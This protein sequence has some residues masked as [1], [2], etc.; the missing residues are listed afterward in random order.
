MTKGGGI[1]PAALFRSRVASAVARRPSPVARA[2]RPS[3]AAAAGKCHHSRARVSTGVRTATRH[4]RGV[5]QTGVAALRMMRACCTSRHHHDPDR[6]AVCRPLL[7]SAPFCWRSAAPSWRRHGAR[8]RSEIPAA[9]SAGRQPPIVHFA[10]ASARM[11]G[12]SGLSA[13]SIHTARSRRRPRSDAWQQRAALLRRQIQVALGL[14][15]LPIRTPLNAR[16]HGTVERDDYVVD[17]VAF[18]SVPGHFVTGSLYRPKNR[19]GTSTRGAVAARSLARRTL[20]GRRRRR[21]R[22]GSDRERGGA[23]SSRRPP[24][25]AGARR[26]PRAHGR[27]HVPVRHGGIRRQ[28]ADPARGHR[29]S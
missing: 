9:G 24:S 7:R 6:S 1:L 2:R 16:V 12:V 17:K 8:R 10:R 15:P 20:S 21:S 13:I 3:P 5:R 11:T 26:A 22:A 28:R 19:T 23:A 14:W 27:R 4:V 25:A 18:E 29:T